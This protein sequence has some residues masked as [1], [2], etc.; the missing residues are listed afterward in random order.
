MVNTTFLTRFKCLARCRHL[1]TRKH[2][3]AIR[4]VYACPAPGTVNNF[5]PGVDGTG[6]EEIC[7]YQFVLAGAG[8]SGPR[9]KTGPTTEHKRDYA[10]DCDVD[11]VIREKCSG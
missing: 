1:I 2:T 3:T 8:V 9:I 5:T 11:Q 7:L 6:P 4:Q 10:L